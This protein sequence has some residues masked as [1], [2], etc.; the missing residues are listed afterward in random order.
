MT[1]EEIRMRSVYVFLTCSQAVEQLKDRLV[2]TFPSPTLS[3]KLLLDVQLRR[4]LGLLFRYWATRKIW[5]QL[6]HDEPGATALNLALLRLFT[7]GLKLS[8]DGSGL[9]YAE[10]STF[11]E[12]VYE[13]SRRLT[14]ALGVEHQPMMET[15]H[16]DLLGW[17]EAVLTHTLE[18][19]EQPLDQLTASVKQWAQRAAEPPPE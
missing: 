8:K 3:S 18:A 6:E 19:L 16:R 10:L 4:E 14:N 11:S 2:A 7:E 17:R 12:E 13:L 5:E 15:L 1:Q 9:R